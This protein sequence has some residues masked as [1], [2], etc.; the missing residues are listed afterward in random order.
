MSRHDYDELPEPV[1]LEDTVAEV[2]TRAVPDPDAGTNRD[3][4]NALEAG[5]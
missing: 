1:R 5:G 3:R 2:D 4:F